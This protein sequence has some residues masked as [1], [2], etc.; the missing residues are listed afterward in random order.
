[1]LSCCCCAGVER[2]GDELLA[3]RLH[4]DGGQPQL[5]PFRGELDVGDATVVVVG[6]ASDE[7]PCLEAVDPSCERPRGDPDLL[8]EPPRGDAI[9]RTV[10]AQRAEEVP[11]AHR[12]PVVGGRLAQ[13]LVE[14]AAELVDPFDEPFGLQIEIGELAA[15]D[16]E[17]AVNG[18]CALGAL[19]HRP[20]S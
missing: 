15:P 18:I 10:P 13:A 5:V 8:R 6:E 2:G 4:R 11:L 3:S 12:Q 20:Q 17:R 19:G 14:V 9:R 1:M 16:L 7:T